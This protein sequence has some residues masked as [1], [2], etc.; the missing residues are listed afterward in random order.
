[1]LEE[2]LKEAIVSELQRQAADRPQSLKVQG[3]GDAAA[4]EEL[5][6]DGKIDLGALVMVIAGSVA[7]GP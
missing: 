2:K 5:T 7:G 3:A 4:S 1:M 6:V